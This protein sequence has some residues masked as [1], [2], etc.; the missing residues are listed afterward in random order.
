MTG[1]TQLRFFAYS[2]RLRWEMLVANAVAIEPGSLAAFPVNRKKNRSF[3]EFRVH[4][5][6]TPPNTQ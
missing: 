1:T 6:L 2:C 4:S 5:G 3:I